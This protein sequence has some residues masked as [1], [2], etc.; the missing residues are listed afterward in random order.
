M[1]Q[2]FICFIFLLSFKMAVLTSLSAALILNSFHEKKKLSERGGKKSPPSHSQL[3]LKRTTRNK[4]EGFSVNKNII[5]NACE[6][7]MTSPPRRG[8]ALGEWQRKCGG[9]AQRK[10][11]T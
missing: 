9:E 10:P 3:D 4:S 2:L 1:I 5:K 11:V 7:V 6:G 8:P